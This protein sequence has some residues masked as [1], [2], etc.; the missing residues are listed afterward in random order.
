MH[1]QCEQVLDNGVTV[2]HHVARQVIFDLDLL[3]VTI[4][5]DSY[6][7]EAAAAQFS[8]VKTQFV[9]I[10]YDPTVVNGAIVAAG[11]DIRAAVYG[12]LIGAKF[13]DGQI[14]F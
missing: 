14:I 9:N 10:P 8:P 1:I 3:Q 13:H 6:T 7:N 12:A 4:V 2:G 11:G 5:L